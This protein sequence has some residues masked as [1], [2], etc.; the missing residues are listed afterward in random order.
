M[1]SGIAEGGASEAAGTPDA[2][3]SPLGR[4]RVLGPLGGSAGSAATGALKAGASSKP[5][6]TSR[7]DVKGSLLHRLEE[8]MQQCKE[9]RAV[10]EDPGWRALRKSGAPA[11]L[12]AEPWD[13]L[14][15]TEFDV[16]VHS[17]LQRL[18]KQ[19]ALALAQHWAPDCRTFPRA[20]EK[21]VPGA[22]EGEGPQPMRSTRHPGGFPWRELVERFGRTAKVVQE[23]LDLHNL[24]ANT[25]AE[26]C[27]KAV[28][29]GR[30]VMVENPV[31]SYLWDLPAY[32]R[33]A[34]MKGMAWVT[35]HN[36]AFGGERR[37]YTAVLTNI[38]GM[39][40][41]LGQHCSARAEDAPCDFSGKPHVTWKA[42][43]KDGFATTVTGPESE[44]PAAMCS[45]MAKP[46]ALCR[47]AAPELATGLPF[48]F[49]E[50]FSGPNAPLTQAVRR[51]LGVRPQRSQ[52]EDGATGLPPRV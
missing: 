36:C 20:L 16:S 22:P 48:A 6:L 5:K 35:F 50:V 51:A 24:M 21:A 17:N 1:E 12:V 19:A 25:A 4:P 23:K 11:A 15:G 47:E 7:A 44:Y 33:L 52:D 27:A 9:R 37:K 49:L 46:I 30:F 28:E 39:R 41:A 31:Q 13:K 40:E 14:R 38:P 26:E 10:A 32:K 3:I 8:A 18:R 29:Q 42:S 45:A 43:W 34:K 2:L